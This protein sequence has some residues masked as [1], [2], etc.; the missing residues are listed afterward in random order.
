MDVEFS[1][2]E[3]VRKHLEVYDVYEEFYG[4][5]QKASNIYNKLPP[6]LM[7]RYNRTNDFFD[8]DEDARQSFLGLLGEQATSLGAITLTTG[9][10]L[11]ELA[12]EIS[13]GLNRHDSESL[14]CALEQCMKRLPVSNIIGKGHHL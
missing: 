9:L 7:H 3:E 12:T 8:Y 14:L 13:D 4:C 6:Q 10:K 5:L 1:L 2:N 11:G